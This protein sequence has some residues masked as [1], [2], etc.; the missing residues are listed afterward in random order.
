MDQKDLIAFGDEHND[1]EMLA[2]AGYGYAMKNASSILL[3]YADSI[4]DFTNNEDGVARQL[5][6]LF[7]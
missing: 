3:P 6:Q 1:T 5:I 4:T 2:L 7:L